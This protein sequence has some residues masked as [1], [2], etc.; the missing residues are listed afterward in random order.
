VPRVACALFTTPSIVDAD[1]PSCRPAMFSIDMS[2]GV[3]VV[4]A[5][6]VSLL[7]FVRG[8][9]L[10]LPPGPPS[11]PVIGHTHLM[12][13]VKYTWVSFYEWS[14]QYSDKGLMFLKLGTSRTFVVNSAKVAHDLFEKRSA[15]YSGRFVFTIFVDGGT[16][17]D[18]WM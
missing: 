3:L 18:R 9:S 16:M 7:L 15:I 11:L 17:A 6:A 12:S 13:G 1:P 10:R 4:A 8:K 2:P 14:K 5:L